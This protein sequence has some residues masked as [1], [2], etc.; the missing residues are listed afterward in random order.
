M[1]HENDS[2]QENW[3]NMIVPACFIE[4]ICGIGGERVHKEKYGDNL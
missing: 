3:I 4:A 1:I 2:A